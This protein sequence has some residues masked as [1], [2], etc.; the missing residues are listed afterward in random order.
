VST[1]W[2][3]EPALIVGLVQAVIVLAIAFGVSLSPTQTAA[4]LGVTSALTAI[5]GSFVTRSQV[6]SP[7]TIAGQ[8]ADQKLAQKVVTP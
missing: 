3:K 8:M 2:E 5:I 4:I 7:A 6:T 1:W